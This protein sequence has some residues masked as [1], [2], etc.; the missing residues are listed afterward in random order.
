M[1]NANGM[2]LL[3]R[4]LGAAVIA[5]AW[6]SPTWAVSFTGTGTGANSDLSAAADFSIS[7]TNLIVKLQNTSSADV[8][9]QTKLL[10]A[11]FFSFSGT[12]TPILTPVSAVLDSGTAVQYT[13]VNGSIAPVS[14]N[15]GGEWGY[16]SSLAAPGG[17]TAGISSSGFDL[18]GS[19]NFNGPQLSDPLALDG[20]DYGI[21]SAGDDT[22]TGNNAITGVGNGARP[23]V[24]NTDP[25]GWAVIYTLA[26]SGGTINNISNVSFQYGTGLTEPNVP[27]T[28]NGG[29][30]NPPSV[31]EPSSLAIAGLSALGLLGYRLRRRAA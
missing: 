21:T 23:Y 24:Q 4:T 12:G 7:G 17:A 18:F 10:T 2:R 3:L 6:A 25:N 19:P 11:V 22:T 20:F 9:S 5:L 27:G 1:I 28:P 14:G 8:L 13:L 29:N 16:G 26:I 30:P 31:P 15:V